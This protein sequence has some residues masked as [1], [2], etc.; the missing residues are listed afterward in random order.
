[1]RVIDELGKHADKRLHLVFDP[2]E[3]R[4]VRAAL[5]EILFGFSV[6]D[7]G[8]VIGTTQEH[9]KELFEKLNKLDLDQENQV[10]LTQTDVQVIRNAHSKTLAKLGPE[11]YTTRTGVALTSGQ[12]LA[13][14]LETTGG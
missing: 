2:D 3:S 13:K 10:L 12:A 4:A 14:Q 1:M 7:F 11:E 9:A 5:G 8:A 6:E